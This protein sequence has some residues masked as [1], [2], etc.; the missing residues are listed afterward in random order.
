MHAMLFVAKQVARRHWDLDSSIFDST[1]FADII[2]TDSTEA[3]KVSV[4][5]IKVDV[6]STNIA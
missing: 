2:V 6:L 3:A 5:F 1:F 4:V